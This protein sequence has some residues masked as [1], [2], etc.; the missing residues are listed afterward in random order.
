MDIADEE[1]EM[2][3]AAK[4]HCMASG[5]GRRSYSDRRAKTAEE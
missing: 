2:Q 1:A 3:K 5:S 4:A